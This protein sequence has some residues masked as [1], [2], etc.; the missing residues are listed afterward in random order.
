LSRPL[1]ECDSRQIPR[2]PIHWQEDFGQKYSSRRVSEKSFCPNFS[3]KS[4]LVELPI[5]WP[6]ERAEGAKT[7]ARFLRLLRFFAARSSAVISV[8]SF[9]RFR[10]F[11]PSCLGR[12]SN[13]TMGRK[14]RKG[15]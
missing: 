3:A 13:Q 11:R 4:G 5:G 1:G 15:A 6:Q 10:S 12:S 7:K 9:V 8:G 2:R 14:E